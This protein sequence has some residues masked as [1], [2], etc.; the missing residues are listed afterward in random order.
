MK[1]IFIIILILGLLFLY[2]LFSLSNNNDENYIKNQELAKN[3]NYTYSLNKK[4]NPIIFE[5][6]YIENFINKEMDNNNDIKNN[7][8]KYNTLIDKNNNKSLIN[9]DPNLVNYNKTYLYPI[10]GLQSICQKKGLKPS[11]MPKSCYLNDVLNP[12]ANCKCEDE[13]GKCKICYDTID[14]N[15]KNSNIVYGGDNF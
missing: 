10:R 6:P 4:K 14:K 1:G 9:S 12:Y 3:F 7:N 8:T 5:K 13:S 2:F 15:T 11:F